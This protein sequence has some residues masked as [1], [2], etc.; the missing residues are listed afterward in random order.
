MSENLRMLGEYSAAM[1]SGDT[2]A[3][4]KFWSEDFESQVTER[5]SPEQV[6]SDVRG[7]EQH[8]GN[9]RGQRSPTWR[10]P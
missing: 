6:G 9:R 8:G 1:E 7:S 2:D 3:V 10:S 5:V 4:Y